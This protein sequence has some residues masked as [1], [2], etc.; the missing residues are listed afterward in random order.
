MENAAPDTA[1]P[2][3]IPQRRPNFLNVL[4]I[5]TFVVSGYYFFNALVGLMVGSKFSSPD[6][7]NI[8]ENLERIMTNADAKGVAFLQNFLDAAAETVNATM[9]HI[10]ELSA[11]GLVVSLLSILGAYIMWKQRKIGFYLYIVAKLIGVIV[12]L[13]LIGVNV[14]TV[15]YYGFALVISVI[16]FVLYGMNMRYLR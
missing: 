10:V 5:L 6:W 11:M 14:L 16:M 15:S 13:V 12:P 7:I 3:P 9:V 2:P 1:S 4:C 8:Y